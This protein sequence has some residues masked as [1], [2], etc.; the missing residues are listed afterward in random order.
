MSDR[1]FIGIAIA[2]AACGVVT[3]YAQDTDGAVRDRLR[4]R[5]ILHN[6]SKRFP[7][8]VLSEN[9]LG[10]VVKRRTDVVVIRPS[11][12]ACHKAGQVIEL[13]HGVLGDLTVECVNP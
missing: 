10:E 3:A 11:N 7:M 9:V 1:A 6:E 2:V 4:Q 5:V 8:V 12:L 13:T